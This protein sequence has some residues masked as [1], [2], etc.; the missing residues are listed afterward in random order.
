MYVKN[1]YWQQRV[2]FKLY[3]VFSIVKRTISTLL[4]IFSYYI[5]FCNY[6]QKYMC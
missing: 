1:N 3:T 2:S 6:L 5:I 4:S